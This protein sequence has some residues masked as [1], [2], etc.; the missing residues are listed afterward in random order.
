MLPFSNKKKLGDTEA[1]VRKAFRLARQA[2]P[3]ILFLDELDALVTNR[4]TML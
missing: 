4:S 1:E 2:S 3:C